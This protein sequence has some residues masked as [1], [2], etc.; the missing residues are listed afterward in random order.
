[1]A[2]ESPLL[3]GTYPPISPTSYDWRA[4]YDLT[5]DAVPD[6]SNVSNPCTIDL[7]NNRGANV[8]NGIAY[9]CD[10]EQIV[11][12]GITL[13]AAIEDDPEFGTYELSNNVTVFPPVKYINAIVKAHP[14]GIDP[15]N[16]NAC[17]FGSA[18]KEYAVQIPTIRTAHRFGASAQPTAAKILSLTFQPPK[19]AQ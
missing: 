16:S 3:I 11:E 5:F 12:G 10:L 13:R 8:Y 17:L 15:N 7:L 18:T 9:I 2:L 14:F 6:Y 1:L 19:S 4:E